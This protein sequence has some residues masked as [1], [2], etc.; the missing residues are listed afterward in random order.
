MSYYENK[1]LVNQYEAQLLSLEEQ[2]AKQLEQIELME[3]REDDKRYRST[4]VAYN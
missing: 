3:G 1:A 2:I 4:V